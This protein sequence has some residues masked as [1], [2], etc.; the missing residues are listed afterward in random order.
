MRYLEAEM[1]S[2]TFIV[3]GVK[4]SDLRILK[5]IEF[6]FFYIRYYFNFDLYRPAGFYK[7]RPMR[8]KTNRN[9]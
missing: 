9:V 4:R 3:F 7:S 1:I 5:T 2:I 6:I 8:H